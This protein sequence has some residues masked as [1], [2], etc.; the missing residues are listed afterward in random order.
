MNMCSIDA[1]PHHVNI[2]LI[3]VNVI[4]KKAMDGEWGL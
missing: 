1:M 3:T 2:T 4:K